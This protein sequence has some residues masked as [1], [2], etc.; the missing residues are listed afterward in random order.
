M[1]NET[2]VPDDDRAKR[3]CRQILV[4][5]MSNIRSLT[6]VNNLAFCNAN[7]H[8][9]HRLTYLYFFNTYLHTSLTFFYVCKHSECLL[10]NWHIMYLLEEANIWRTCVNANSVYSIN[11]RWHIIKFFVVSLALIVSKDIPRTYK[12]YIQLHIYKETHIHCI[13]AR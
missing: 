3:H 1:R 11:E 5:Q 4:K 7:F 2:K 6:G 12:H 9:P 8:I 10:K 13:C